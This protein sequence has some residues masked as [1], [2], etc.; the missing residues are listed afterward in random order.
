MAKT[1]Y[2]YI[3]ADTPSLKGSISNFKLYPG[4]KLGPMVNLLV[5]V[6]IPEDMELTRRSYAYYSVTKD[7]RT[8]EDLGYDVLVK[9][10]SKWKI[11]NIL[12]GKSF[13]QMINELKK[14]G[15]EELGMYGWLTRLEYMHAISMS[16]RIVS[17]C[18]NILDD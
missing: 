5:R 2:R 17:K 16:R 7:D 6:H 3:L 18:N 11:Q 14:G 15:Y 9:F 13:V 10:D 12:K 8:L 1:R 4:N